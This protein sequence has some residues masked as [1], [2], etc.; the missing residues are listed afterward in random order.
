VPSFIANPNRDASDT[1]AGF[2]YQVDVTLLRWLNLQADE[3]LELERGEDIDT[4]QK[5]LDGGDLRTLEQVKRR[6]SPVTLRSPDALAAIANFSEHKTN[7]PT[8]RLRF[9]FLTTGKTGKEKKWPLSG[10]GIEAWEAL[11]QGRLNDRDRAAIAHEIRSFL[12]D[13]PKPEKLSVSAWNSLQELLAKEDETQLIELI[14]SF[15]WSTGARDDSSSQEAIRRALIES[16]YASDEA[17]AQSIL[18]RLFVH[19]FRKLSQSG[20]KSLT[21]A[22]LSEQLLQPPLTGADRQLFSVLTVIRE[23]GKRLDQLEERF[24]HEQGLVAALGAQIAQLKDEQGKSVKIEYRDLIPNLDRPEIAQPSV[25]RKDF[26]DKAATDLAGI[27]WVH[28]VGEPGIG[29]TQLGLLVSQHLGSIPFWINLRDCTEDQACTILDLS[30]AAASGVDRRIMIREW[31]GEAASRMTGAVFVIDDLPKIFASG[32]LAQRLELFRAACSANGIRLLSTSYYELPKA[33][34]TSGNASELNAPRLENREIDELL[35]LHGAPESLLNEGFVELLATLTQRLPILVTAVA[36]FF[37]SNNWK[38]EASSLQSVFQGEFAK[39]IR[40]DAERVIRATVSD[41]DTRELL[42]RLRL[43]LG[44][45]SRSEVEAVASVSKR[46][47]LAMEKLKHLTGL[48]VQEYRQG[49]YRTSALLDSSISGYLDSKTRRGV[50]AILALRVLAKKK[51]DSFAVFNGFYHFVAADLPQQAV[52]LLI[53]ALWALLE[54]KDTVDE[55]GISDIWSDR[56]LPTSV[57]INLRLFLR[58]LQIA[59][60]DRRGREPSFLREDFERLVQESK[61]KQLWGLFMAASF[62]SIQFVFTRPAWA[63]RYLLIALRNSDGKTI[64][65]PDGNRI[66]IPDNMQLETA[67]W[68][69]AHKTSSDE[70]V[71]DW[72]ATIAQLTPDQLERLKNSEL[73]K[74]NAVLLCEAIW[75]REYRKPEADRDWARV[76]RVLRA[77]EATAIRV[78]FPLLRAAAIRTQ[79]VI[80]AEWEEKIDEAI[81]RA[82]QAVAESG[83]DDERFLLLEVTGRQMIYADRWDQGVKWLQDALA[84]HAIGFPIWKRNALITLS[85]G[86]GR[87]NASDAVRHTMEAVEVAEQSILEPMQTAE[88]LAEHSIALWFASDRVGALHALE[89]GVEILITREEAAL[90]KKTFLL[91]LHIAGYFG[92]MSFSGSPPTASFAIP[93][94]GMFLATDNISEEAYKPVQRSLL[95]IRMAMF[96]DGVGDMNAARIWTKR[97]LQLSPNEVGLPTLVQSFSWL[98]VAPDL[99]SNDWQAVLQTAELILQ[100]PAI[101]KDTFNEIDIPD[102]ADRAEASEI[103]QNAL[104]DRGINKAVFPLVVRLATLKLSGPIRHELSEVSKLLSARTK[105]KDDIWHE[106]SDLI[107]RVFSPDS[108]WKSLYERV[109]KY[110]GEGRI[111]LGMIAMVGCILYSPVKQSLAFQVSFAQTLA[112]LFPKRSSIWR[113]IIEPL[114]LAYWRRAASADEVV[115]RTSQN[116]VNRRL[117]EV[118]QGDHGSRLRQLLREMVFCVGLNVPDEDRSWLEADDSVNFDA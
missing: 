28:V 69:T 90:W 92:A 68:V 100:L 83:T 107:D 41:P 16:H 18:E 116:Y 89:R 58:A 44:D 79:I 81:R 66:N 7:N 105:E 37:A 110:Y 56:P 49:R 93:R 62:L 86:I 8:S 111:G 73:A 103:G 36:R 118:S 39:G 27:T 3:V 87:L 55:W 35:R 78:D 106:V 99:L 14:E 70:D 38:V 115:F 52:I 29:K 20:P 6:S 77:V 42:Y 95:F 59:S 34:P 26:V 104:R 54:R 25:L 43:I 40:E 11:R 46:I 117:D 22:E 31:Y 48:W 33:I 94:R 12:K 74:D 13:C 63:N 5:W 9:R 75:L 76:T 85:E 114:F 4:I 47:D 23:Q 88:A 102:G 113:E 108:D 19:V 96:A 53:Q 60:F 97:A 2:V 50:H 82:E 1:I 80:L 45:F 10:T 57:D 15:E 61:G 24:S 109:A 67:L 30:I 91:F 98:S 112:K 21:S 84:L 72:L 64:P 65:L 32:R 17:G 71:E 101:P 51:L